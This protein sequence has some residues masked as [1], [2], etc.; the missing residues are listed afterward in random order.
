[1]LPGLIDLEGPLRYLL[2]ISVAQSFPRQAIH[3]PTLFFFKTFLK[4][5]TILEIFI[6]FVTILLLFY[7]LVCWL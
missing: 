3:F 7:V 6:E 2:S 5:W 1:M 4:I